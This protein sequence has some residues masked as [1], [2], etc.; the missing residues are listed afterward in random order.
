MLY[1]QTLSSTLAVYL[2]S[3][4]LSSRETIPALLTA[5][6]VAYLNK[7]R[8]PYTAGLWIGSMSVFKEVYERTEILS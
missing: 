4:G 7:Y 1:Q 6:N 2:N 8:R 3:G 5:E